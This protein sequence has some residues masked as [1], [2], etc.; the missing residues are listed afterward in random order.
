MYSKK[1]FADLGLARETL[2]RIMWGLCG[3]VLHPPDGYPCGHT[4]FT[5]RSPASL[6]LIE[7]IYL[8][9]LCTFEK[10]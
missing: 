10:V 9:R 2:A 3:P 4:G 1:N 5:Q 6:T 7:F 8:F